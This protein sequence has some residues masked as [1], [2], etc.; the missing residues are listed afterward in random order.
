M[1]IVQT[2]DM[3][4]WSF[5]GGIAAPAAVAAQQGDAP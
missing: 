2:T 4:D 5:G 3:A 1:V